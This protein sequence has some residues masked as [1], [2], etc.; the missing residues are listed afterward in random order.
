MMRSNHTL[1]RAV[2][3]GGCI[4]LAMDCVLGY[5]QQ[6]QWPTAQLGR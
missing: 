6:R 1:E 2:S 4:V 3:H 5:A